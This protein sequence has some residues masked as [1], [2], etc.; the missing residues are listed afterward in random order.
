MVEA[1]SS[2]AA[3]P[4]LLM[5]VLGGLPSCRFVKMPPAEIAELLAALPEEEL[6]DLLDD[7]HM[8]T[9][10]ECHVLQVSSCLSLWC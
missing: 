10:T 8:R 2:P 3:P 6:E 9:P 1:V 5:R 4:P 7:E